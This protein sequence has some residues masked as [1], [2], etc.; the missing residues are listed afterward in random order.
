MNNAKSHCN[1][2]RIKVLLPKSGSLGSRGKRD[3]IFASS[4]SHSNITEQAGS[5]SSSIKTICIGYRMIGRQKSIGKIA[6]P[7]IGIWTLTI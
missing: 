2:L 6:M 5:I 1:T 3:I 7:A 4:F